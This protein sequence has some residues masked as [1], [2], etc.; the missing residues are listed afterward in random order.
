MNSFWHE[1]H[2]RCFK[3]FRFRIFFM[4]EKKEQTFPNTFLSHQK[5]LFCCQV[6]GRI[7]LFILHLWSVGP[8]LGFLSWT[9]LL[10]YLV[11]S[12]LTVTFKSGDEVLLGL[13]RWKKQLVSIILDFLSQNMWDTIR[14]SQ[15]SETPTDKTAKVVIV[16][17]SLL[18]FDQEE[19]SSRFNNNIC[20]SVG[21]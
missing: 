17:T 3:S 1:S 20:N 13:I 14:G 15:L 8:K 7:L 10:V 16:K 12:W 5:W 6:T 2:S 9:H 18:S 4:R 21:G 11:V 19:S